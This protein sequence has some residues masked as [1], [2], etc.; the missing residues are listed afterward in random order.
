MAPGRIMDRTR[1]RFRAHFA[2]RKR[3]A[4]PLE[5]LQ[6]LPRRGVRERRRR[7][8]M[9]KGTQGGSRSPLVIVMLLVAA[10]ALALYFGRDLVSPGEPPTTGTE[11]AE[12]GDTD[13]T[14]SDSAASADASADEPGSLAE[15]VADKIVERL[16]EGSGHETQTAG[17]SVSAGQASAEGAASGFG[18]EAVTPDEDRAAADAGDS[19]TLRARIPPPTLGR[20]RADATLAKATGCRPIPSP[21]RAR[22]PPR[23][24]CGRRSRPGP[25]CRCRPEAESVADATPPGAGRRRDRVARQRRRR[26]G[27]GSAAKRRDRDRDDR[28]RPGD[29][30]RRRGTSLPP[31]RPRFPRKTAKTA[32]ARSRRP[33]M[34]AIPSPRRVRIPPPR[35]SIPPPMPHRKTRCR[36][37]RRRVP[38][39]PRRLETGRK[40]PPAT[41]WKR[42]CGQA[43]R[44]G[45][46]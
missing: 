42:K 15:Q 10:V 28:R 25:R 36:P 41:P 40:A 44:P 17:E 14:P 3:N 1:P 29:R 9:A 8:T 20:S 18:E 5:G 32:P 27:R 26:P 6:C 2:P 35:R 13:A 38:P 22:I 7:A 30:I 39:S 34:R 19:V 21:H 24:R 46:R 31:T 16:E 37:A 45:P 23:G 4:E 11:S 12:Q 33:P 43:A